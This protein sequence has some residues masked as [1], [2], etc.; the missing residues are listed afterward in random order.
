VLSNKQ[1]IIKI[2]GI[3]KSDLNISK[4]KDLFYSS[5]KININLEYF[6][7]KNIKITIRDII[8][9][10]SFENYDKRLFDET[11]KKT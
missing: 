7:K 3:N 5:S 10:V 1:E 6:C 11:K 2:K 8:K 9:N 4:F